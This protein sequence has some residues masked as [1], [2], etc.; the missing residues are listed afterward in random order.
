MT[1]RQLIKRLIA[2]QPVERCGF[3]LGNPH[4]D[5]WP[6]LHR[7]FGTA[8]EEELRRKL[9]DE[10][11]WICPQFYPDAYRDPQGRGLFDASLDR[12]KH[13]SVGPL[14]DCSTVAEVERFPWPDP[15]CLNFET[16]LRDLR[17]AG[18]VYRL[19][20]FWTCFYHNLADLFG[21]ENYFMKMHTHPQVVLAATDRVCEF[22]YEANERFFAAAG[23]LMDGFFFGNDF[24]C[25]AGL[26]CSPWDL[27]AFV[28]PWFQRFVEQGRRH[29]YQVVVHSC[30]SV[31]RLIPRMIEAGVDCLHPLQARARDMSAERLAGDFKGR[32]AFLGG[33][34]AQQVMTSGTPDEIRADVRRVKR[35]L[36]PNL[37][38]SPS[39]EAILPNVPPENVQALAEAAWEPETL[40]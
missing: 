40:A 14:A 37:I 20:G 7:H 8:T 21:M 19:S 12:E 28:F 30:G 13:G 38:V 3:W 25:Q 9:G 11:R 17:E 6:I 15:D 16:C 18:D 5:T 1:S 24:G 29:G 34:D 31:H 26:V 4:P 32:V 39:H 2:R 22:Y 27:D 33:I 35:L 36:G 23:D 10:V